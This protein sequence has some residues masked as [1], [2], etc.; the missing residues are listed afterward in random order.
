M[1]KSTPAKLH[2]PRR[3]YTLH[4]GDQ[5]ERV[6]TTVEYLDYLY[7]YVSVGR[8]VVIQGMRSVGALRRRRHSHALRVE[9]LAQAVTCGLS[10]GV[11]SLDT[12]LR[13]PYT[14]WPRRLRGKIQMFLRQQ[15]GVTPSRLTSR[16][17]R[18]AHETLVWTLTQDHSP[19]CVPVEGIPED[20]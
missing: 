10:A 2:V 13:R 11:I 17:W 1:T 19:V 6:H 3:Y 4:D 8:D 9:L 16:V 18:E 14:A 12:L 20:N 15:F 5:R 7:R